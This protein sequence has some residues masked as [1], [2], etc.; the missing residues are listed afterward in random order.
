VTQRGLTRSPAHI[1]GQT[2]IDQVLRNAEAGQFELGYTVLLPCIFNLYL[3]PDDYARLSGIFAHIREDARRA[4][5]D[6]IAQLNNPSP[7]ALGFRGRKFDHKEYKIAGS[8]FVFEFFS[9]DDGSVPLGDVEIHSELA[10]TP[11]PG[12]HGVRTTL[13]ER[14]PSVQTA[15]LD[16]MS[17]SDGLNHTIEAE[18]AADAS[19]AVA[20]R[21]Y[22]E[23]RYEDDSGPQVYLITQDE[24]SIGRGGDGRIVDLA[25]YSDD[26]ISREHLR[27]RRDPGR[28]RFVIVDRSMNGTA[29][30]GR[31]LVR[32][33]EEALPS[34][35]TIALADQIKMQFEQR[36]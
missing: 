22:A 14:E 18:H 21:V 35:A 5:R 25:L 2:I 30:N 29:V 11:R 19:L 8:D 24:I 12:F 23:I 7:R 17:R 1:G 4:L 31:K 15:R 3:H 34:K 28:N 16:A 9:D 36:S 6:R 32:D 10:E 20:E 27:L 13:I 26:E 33:I